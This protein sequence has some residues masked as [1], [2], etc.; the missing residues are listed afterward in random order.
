MVSI[1]GAANTGDTGSKRARG[2]GLAAWL[3]A[4]CAGLVFVV[5]ACGARSG[6]PEDPAGES[7]D[8]TTPTPC[9]PGASK[10]CGSDVGACKKGTRSCN[11][12]GLLGECQGGI[13]PVA[14]ACNGVDDDCDGTVDNG[15][16]LGEAC[17]GP[18]TD[19]CPDDVMTCNGCSTG[20]NTVETCNGIDDDCNGIIDSDCSVGGCKPTLLVTG[21]VASQP[22]C[23]DFPVQA[24]TTGRIEYPC[25]GG[26][27]SAT[28]GGVSF[29]GS[30]KGGQVS[31]TGTQVFGPGQTQDGCTWQMTHTIQGNVSSGSLAYF[32]SEAL[33]GG[34]GACWSPCTESGTVKVQWVRGP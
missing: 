19:L 24:N 22:G 1:V 28:L 18:D 6:L 17:D 7:P 25:E 15:F 23:F 9:A 3:C 2:G 16:G 13:H 31:L 11:A 21:S 27:V 26:A 4:V 12:D 8:S 5:P 29:T 34:G 30:V 10:A 33:V 20:P 32:Y 14:E